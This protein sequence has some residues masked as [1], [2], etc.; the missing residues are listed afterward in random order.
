[1]TIT[2]GTQL[3]DGTLGAPYS[4]QMSASGGIPPYTWAANGLPGGLT[5][6]P[7]SGTISGTP[8]MAGKVSPAVTVSDSTKVATETNQFHINVNLPTVPSISISGLPA[9]AGPAQQ[10]GLQIGFCEGCS[11]YPVPIL[12]TA[13]L[14]FSPDVG[15]GDGTIQFSTG[16]TTASF[17]IPAGSTTATFA[18]PFALQTGT[19]AGTI[20]VSLSGL[21]AGGL[22]VTPTPAPAISA[23]VVQAAPVIQ[24]VQVSRTANSLSIQITGYS[25]AR[26]VTQ[27][28]FT[29]SAGQGQTLQTSQI[30]IPVDTL[31]SAWYQNS[32]NNA[33][34]SQFILTQ[35]FS[36]QGDPSAVLPQTVTLT[37]REGTVT[38]TI[39][40]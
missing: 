20:N 14:T 35:P 8:S 6:D 36:I 22:D 19:V 13:I 39:G 23:H 26:E 37:N 5:I 38:Y 12:G 3:P 21:L 16:G 40:Q 25:T 4:Y 30:T 7:N 10:Y 17:T 11:P 9:T 33:Y 32:A 2:T 29:F 28:V 15:G 31:F 27:A 34:G 18:A 24:S 1:L